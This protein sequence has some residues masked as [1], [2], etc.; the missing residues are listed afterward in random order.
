MKKILLDDKY[1]IKVKGL[2]ADLYINGNCN[3]NYK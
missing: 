3:F 2:I 1:T